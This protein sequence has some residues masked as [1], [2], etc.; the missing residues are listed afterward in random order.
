MDDTKMETFST[1][2][3]TIMKWGAQ[4]TGTKFKEKKQPQ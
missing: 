2:R 1:I 4:M 3:R